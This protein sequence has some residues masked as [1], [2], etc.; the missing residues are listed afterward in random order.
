LTIA[1][2]NPEIHLSIIHKY[3]FLFKKLD[4]GN[5]MTFNFMSYKNIKFLS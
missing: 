2:L 3:H 1:R 4:L 5:E